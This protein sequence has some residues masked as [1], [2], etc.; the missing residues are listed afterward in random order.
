ML[1]PE[2]TA[3]LVIDVQKKLIPVM[4]ESEELLK[5]I[6]LL[7]FMC[8]ELRIPFVVT[9]Q[10][11]KGLGETYDSVKEL[12]G[13]VAPIAKTAFSAFDVPEVCSAFTQN[14][15]K[16][17]IVCGVEAH[18]CVRLSVL[19]AL[20]RGYEVT[21]IADAVASR[22]P[23]HLHYALADMRDAGAHILPLEALIFAL[24]KDSKH[25]KFKVFSDAIKS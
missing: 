10:Y 21:V 23:E 3:C 1:T 8:K 4:Y 11:P 12:M 6:H 15:P 7:T 19:D 22:R 13:D 25:P 9:E 18:V 14:P 2:Q 16:H 5:Q 20:A 17:L 24:L